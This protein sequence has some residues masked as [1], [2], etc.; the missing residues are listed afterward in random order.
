MEFIICFY[1]KAYSK[2]RES[3]V[4]LGT[5]LLPCR[6][7]S[8]QLQIAAAAVFLL[9]DKNMFKCSKSNSYP[10]GMRVLWQEKFVERQ[11]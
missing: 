4:L 8:I 10:L 2:S 1:I 5:Y 6:R 7:R 9:M 11:R 3:F